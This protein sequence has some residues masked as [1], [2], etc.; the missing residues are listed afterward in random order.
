MLAQ[1]TVLR[2]IGRMTM[3]Q[4]GLMLL[5]VGDNLRCGVVII[6]VDDLNG[7]EDAGKILWLY[8]DTQTFKY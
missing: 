4:G 6:K 1:I 2:K 7:Q 3:L 5:Y 8:L